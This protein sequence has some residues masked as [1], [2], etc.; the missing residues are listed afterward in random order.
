MRSKF[1]P[2]RLSTEELDANAQAAAASRAKLHEEI[3]EPPS[4]KF[5]A[6]PRIPTEPKP[7]P[8]TGPAPSPS[9]PNPR[10]EYVSL[11]PFR[12]TPWDVAHIIILRT[13]PQPEYP[14]ISLFLKSFLR[15]D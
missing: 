8:P 4:P 14:P 7:R 15:G 5:N 3:P 13:L 10:D 12:P 2:V 6:P 9:V 11:D 1:D